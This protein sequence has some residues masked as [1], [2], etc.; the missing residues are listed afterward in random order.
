MPAAGQSRSRWPRGRQGW[1]GS[2]GRG[3]ASVEQL[4][5][6]EFRVIFDAKM[7]LYFVTQFCNPMAYFWL[8]NGNNAKRGNAREACIDAG[9]QRTE[10]Y[11]DKLKN[12]LLAV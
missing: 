10:T 7:R 11:Y 2:D 3:S 5:A 12:G 6:S 1:R 4:G 8:T 9:W